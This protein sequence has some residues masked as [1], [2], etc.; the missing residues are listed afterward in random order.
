[1]HE[2]AARP[3]LWNDLFL[4]AAGIDQKKANKSRSLNCCL[5]WEQS[6]CLCGRYFL[7]LFVINF[8]TAA[9]RFFSLD[10]IDVAAPLNW[11][12]SV[13]DLVAAVL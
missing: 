13:R 6:R 8:L 4:R 7:F 9:V 1:M 11:N 3:G 10:D 12:T 5:H 2:Q